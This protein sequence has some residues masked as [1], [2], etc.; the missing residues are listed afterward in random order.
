[1]RYKTVI[2]TPSYAISNWK[3]VR[4]IGYDVKSFLEARGC[5]YVIFML[6][7]D[8]ALRLSF[9]LPDERIDLGILY[10]QLTIIFFNC[11]FDPFEKV[12]ETFNG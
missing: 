5:S 3:E 6:T 1:M 11:N 10:E 12:E 7:D 4:K 8:L 9:K 2:H